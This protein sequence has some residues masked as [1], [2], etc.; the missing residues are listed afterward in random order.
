MP[1]FTPQIIN[2]TTPAISIQEE[3]G[4]VTYAQIKQSLGTYVYNVKKLY[5][6]S[7]NLSQLIGVINY[8]SYGADGN[9][10]ITNLTTTYDPYQLVTSLFVDISKY[11]IDVIFD[12]NSS[13]STNILPNTSVQVKFMSKRITNSFGR[14]LDNFIFGEFI[15]N[16]PDF[17]NNYGNLKKIQETNKNIED[18]ISNKSK[19]SIEGGEGGESKANIKPKQDNSLV[20]M[21]SVAAISIGAWFYLKKK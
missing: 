7:D 20:L 1:T 3:G 21:F 9:R 14:N 5:L 10:N 6:Y 16:K 12:G 17:F 13:V 11:P 19:K 18:S 8:N 15:A 4:S 2:N